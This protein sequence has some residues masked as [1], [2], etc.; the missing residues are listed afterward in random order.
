MKRNL[1]TPLLTL[2]GKP[3]DDNAT[4]KSVVFMVLTAPMEGDDKMS[5]EAKMKQYGLIKTVHAGGVVDLT[6]EDITTI[7]A[8]GAKALSML[9]FGLM[10]DML[11]KE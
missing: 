4:L 11:E 10:V 8:R 3:F 1:D 7:K 9:A 5:V 6:A 2:D